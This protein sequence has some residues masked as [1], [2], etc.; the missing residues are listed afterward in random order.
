[1]QDL[2]TP[3]FLSSSLSSYLL[4][5]PL[6]TLTLK[7]DLLVQVREWFMS[8]KVHDR[9]MHSI[10]IHIQNTLHQPSGSLQKA[11]SFWNFSES[12][13]MEPLT[14]QKYPAL[15]SYFFIQLSFFERKIIVPIK[16]ARTAS[17][18]GGVVFYYELALLRWIH[19]ASKSLI[20]SVQLCIY[21]YTCCVNPWQ[22]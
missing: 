7:N 12:G 16:G 1:M 4:A 2:L 11:L 13:G 14:E 19:F 21:W 6:N 20:Y 10:H 15:W 9:E 22:P 8:P 18:T 5:L 3:A 17:Y